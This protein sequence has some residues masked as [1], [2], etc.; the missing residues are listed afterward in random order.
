MS[1]IFAPDLL[2]GQAAIVTGGGTGIGRGIALELARSGAAVALV[3]RRPEPLQA[4]AEEIKELGR[5]AVALPADVRNWE[6]VQ[7]MTTAA[8]QALGRLDVLV[9]NAGGQFGQ[10]FKEMSPNGWR[11]VVDLNLNGVFN[12]TRAASDYLIPQGSG[13]VINIVTGFIRRGAPNL[14]HQGAARAGVENLTRSLA[15]EWAPYN[16]QVNCISPVVM[17]EAMARNYGGSSD[18]ADRFVR[19]IPA[20]RTGT[21][22]E[23]GWLVVYLASRA[24]DYMTGE[25]LVLDG[26]YW[27]SVGINAAGYGLQAQPSGPREQV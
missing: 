25:H 10:P 13:K 16:I 23:V 7:A 19:S 27:L 11:A 2:A 20:G 17:T 1:S 12:C 21:A 26:G 4:V 14:A 3:G 8:V 15:L 18:A 6:Q 22:E 9:N 24:G 5:E